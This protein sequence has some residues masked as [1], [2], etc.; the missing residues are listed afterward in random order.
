M[1][2]T[3]V[4][5]RSKVKKGLLASLFTAIILALLAIFGFLIKAGVSGLSHSLVMNEQETNGLNLN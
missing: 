4:K 1:K 3:I 2:K 5:S